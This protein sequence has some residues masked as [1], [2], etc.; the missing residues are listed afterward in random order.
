MYLLFLLTKFIIKINI[1][2]LRRFKFILNLIRKKVR[3]NIRNNINILI[4]RISKFCAYLI[5]HYGAI[6]IILRIFP[7]YLIFPIAHKLQCFGARYQAWEVMSNKQASQKI[8]YAFLA[9]DYNAVS[10]CIEAI[11]DEKRKSIR[12]PQ[13]YLLSKHFSWTLGHYAYIDTVIKAQKLGHIAKGTLYLVIKKNHKLDEYFA[14]FFS[15]YVKT[16]YED[17]V[18][19][20][21]EGYGDSLDEI[22]IFMMP[23]DNEVEVFYKYCARIEQEWTR[24]NIEIIPYIKKY[25][26]EKEHDRLYEKYNIPQGSKI[27]LLHVRESGFHYNRDKYNRSARNADID[28]YEAT[29]KYLIDQGYFI[30]RMGDPSMKKLDCISK[31][32]L[33][34]AH[35]QKKS[36]H[37]DM[38]FCMLCEFYIGTNSG[39]SFFP[40]LFKKRSVL[41]N[42]VPLFI[43]NHYVHDIFIPKLIWHKKH[44]RYLTFSEMFSG[45]AANSQFIDEFENKPYELHDNSPEDILTAVKEMIALLE[46]STGYYKDEDQ[47]L[48]RQFYN[49]VDYNQGFRGSQI[50]VHFLKKYSYLIDNLTSMPGAK[51]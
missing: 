33:D 21:R 12:R 42:W 27:I 9:G 13:A 30:V 41:T 47:N 49:I 46:N 5:I 18:R 36:I 32:I 1:F 40:P 28:S 11:N 44:K 4:E 20:L 10:Y 17:N 15:D 25:N 37:D 16:V 7:N 3:N 19:L 35:C 24:E 23:Y 29:V 14:E 51:S 48:L 2:F 50:S 8:S 6:N 34:Y 43:P 38:M 45:F 26:I 39:L 22:S 31:N